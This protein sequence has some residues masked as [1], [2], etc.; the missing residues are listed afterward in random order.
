MGIRLRELGP[1]CLQRYGEIPIRFRVESVLRV[2]EIDGGLGGLALREE[3]VAEPYLRD[4]DTYE[5]EGPA[6]WAERW[7]VSRWGF[8]VAFDGEEPVG[9]AGL[10]F[11]SPGVSMLDGRTDLAVLWDLRVRPERRREGIG[12]ALL[13]RSADWARERD[14][15][16]L[17]IETQNTNVAACRFY[18]ACGCRLGGILRHA[19]QEPDLAQDV[20]L[21]WYLEL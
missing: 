6:R 13:R 10:A 7:D 5:E 12:S 4:Y 8:L 16:Q 3:R 11:R 15:T 18:A 9:G 1:E 21:L 19:Y 14:C 17:K 2:E 20:M